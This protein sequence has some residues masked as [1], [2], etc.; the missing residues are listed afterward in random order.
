M[1]VCLSVSLFLCL[2]CLSVCFSPGGVTV[3]VFCL[4][5]I[6]LPDSYNLAGDGLHNFVHKTLFT[7][8]NTNLNFHF[9]SVVCSFLRKIATMTKTVT[10]VPNRIR[11]PGGTII[12][13]GPI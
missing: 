6:S 7:L 11:E 4:L 10:A 5:Q 1:S 2:S 13:T 8:S 12:A 9:L 3:Y